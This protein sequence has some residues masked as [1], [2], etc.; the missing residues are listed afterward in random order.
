[1]DVMCRKYSCVYN[2]RA[3]C[4]RKH[5]EVNGTSDCA[6]LEIDNEK[7]YN[8]INTLKRNVML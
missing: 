8:Y 4:E 2:D 7:E 5:L 1:M 6:D 3:K